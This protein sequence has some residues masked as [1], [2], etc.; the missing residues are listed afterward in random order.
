M[1]AMDDV[2]TTKFKNMRFE[3]LRFKD[4]LID[5][6]KNKK[7][8][9]ALDEEFIEKKLS[10]FLNFPS[11]NQSKKN[12]MEK[13]KSSKDYKQFRKSKEHDFL[14]KSLRAELRKIYGVFM[15]EDNK[16]KFEL[17]ANI[18]PIIKFGPSDEDL[19][20]HRELLSLHR[21]T[22]ERLDYYPFIYE[23][24]F[25]MIDKEYDGSSGESSRL[26]FLDLACGLNPLSCI[27]FRERIKKYYASDISKDDCDFIRE[28]F[29]KM[30]IQAEVFALDL[31]DEKNLPALEKIKADVCFLFKTLDSLE[32]SN[33]GIS[34][35]LLKSI[36]AR[37]IV[38]SFPKVSISGKNTIALSKRAWLEKI[39]DGLFEYE[40]FEIPQELFYLIKT[41]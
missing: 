26:V 29:A 8:L 36:D 18:H 21:S 4:E 30:N 25:S 32:R 13:L 35:K 27:Y 39:L 7:E 34:E 19:E 38:I 31:S 10:A 28:Y 15:Q 37:F 16:K 41:T 40:K 1:T 14:I 3:D 24:I 33:K 11:N 23:K 2:H 9:K 17:L 5:D 12:I 22:E 6:I 20:A